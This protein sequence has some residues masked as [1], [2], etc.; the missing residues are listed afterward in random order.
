M[1]MIVGA[2]AA[3]ALLAGAAAPASAEMNVEQIAGQLGK[4]AGSQT[5]RLVK[6]RRDVPRYIEHDSSK[7]P[8]GSSD[9]WRQV[10]R[11][12]GGRRR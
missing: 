11:E 1:K 8:F 3:A 7:L 5:V 6:E 10:E 4:M 9:W 12:Q 2:L